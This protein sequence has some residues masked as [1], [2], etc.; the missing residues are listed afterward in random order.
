MLSGG[1]SERSREGLLGSKER[2]NRS[3]GRE[4]NLFRYRKTKERKLKRLRTRYQ[5]VGGRDHGKR[6]LGSDGEDN[7]SEGSTSGYEDKASVREM[8]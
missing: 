8:N 2:H 6:L 1:G 7:R 3:E 5:E 4:G